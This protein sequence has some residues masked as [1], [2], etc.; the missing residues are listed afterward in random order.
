MKPFK[1][2]CDLFDNLPIFR[3]I[4]LIYGGIFSISLV[5]ISLIISGSVSFLFSNLNRNELRN[6]AD[7]V[8]QYILNGDIITSETLDKI[9]TNDMVEINLIKYSLEDSVIK[10]EIIQ[11][12]PQSAY[13]QKFSEKAFHN[14]TYDTGFNTINIENRKVLYYQKRI[15]YNNITYKIQTFNI[16]YQQQ[17][18]LHFLYI[19]FILANLIGIVVSFIIGS[20]ISRKILNPIKKIRNAA[21]RI[22]IE[23]LSQ[24]IDVSGPNDELKD[25]A[26]T[27]NDMIERLDISFKKQNRFVSDASHELRTPIAVIQ[28]YVNLIDRWGKSDP[29]ILQE[30]IDSIKSETEH[31]S[32]LVKRLL[33]LAKGDQNK[34]QFQKDVVNLKEIGN[35]IVKEVEI[36]KIK[37]KFI[38]DLKGECVNVI[39]D[40]SLI[41]QMIWV[42][43]ENSIKYTDSNKAIS[44][45]I[46]KDKDNA[47]FSVK[48][49]GK[50][51]PEN[52]IPFIFDRF[53]RVDKSRSKDI[54]GTGLG[55]SIAQWIA[56]QHKAKIRVFSQLNKGTNMIVVFPLLKNKNT[57]AN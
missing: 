7:S 48:D 1:R 43:V 42:L 13:S 5:L 12:F 23:D 35:E 6:I 18:Q 50:G 27:F 14:S 8:E 52:D 49:K 22:S 54:P 9:N 10:A 33:F 41:K 21:K 40:Y 17:Q 55:L 44:I 57:K 19:I 53:Y 26:I 51:I 37:Q 32:K 31:M 24:R 45:D 20:Y 15:N 56:D 28:G 16:S 47:Y 46:Y 34:T 2:L 38:Y 36:M 3:K 4:G 29:D 11:S 30:S 25:L 39:G